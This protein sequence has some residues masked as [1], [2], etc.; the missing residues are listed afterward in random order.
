MILGLV[1][2]YRVSYGVEYTLIKM[3][4]IFKQ[5]CLFLYLKK[6]DKI[7]KGDKKKYKQK[8]LYL[9]TLNKLFPH[10]ILLIEK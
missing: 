7:V 8:K 10:L 1:L 3:R 4:D 9:N 2:L 5:N 6:Y